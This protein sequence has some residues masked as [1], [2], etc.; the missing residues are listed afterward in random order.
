MLDCLGRKWLRQSA[1]ISNEPEQP[2]IP[3]SQTSRT[4]RQPQTNSQTSSLTRQTT[5]HGVRCF[6]WLLGWL[7]SQPAYPSYFSWMSGCSCGSVF[8]NERTKG[9]SE[10]PCSITSSRTYPSFSPEGEKVAEG[11]MRGLKRSRPLHLL[12]TP[13]AKSVSKGEARHPT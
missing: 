11:R 12:T 4:A 9:K 13:S 2:D 6:V 7:V 10:I 3:N 1:T 5:Q 8:S